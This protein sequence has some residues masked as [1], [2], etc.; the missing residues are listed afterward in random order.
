MMSMNKEDLRE[1]EEGLYG[2]LEKLKNLLKAKNKHLYERWK[3]G[4]FIVDTNIVS[5]YPNAQDVIEQ[6]QD[7]DEDDYDEE[8]DE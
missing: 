2:N 8:G 6:L 4:G 5:M 1:I 7:E 3:A